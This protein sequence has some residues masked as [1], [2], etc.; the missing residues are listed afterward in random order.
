MI[1]RSL[2]WGFRYESWISIDNLQS[3]FLMNHRPQEIK[4]L[5]IDRSPI[6]IDRC[7]F[8]TQ[9]SMV[10]GAFTAAFI[11][12]WLKYCPCLATLACSLHC[13]KLCLSYTVFLHR[14][15][16]SRSDQHH[17]KHSRFTTSYLYPAQKSN[18]G[19]SCA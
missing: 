9:I 13:L 4:V 17:S 11:D 16:S 1:A 12:R 10:P 15:F 19:D 6:L 18:L 8:L 2:Y 3:D 14:F 5:K 7:F